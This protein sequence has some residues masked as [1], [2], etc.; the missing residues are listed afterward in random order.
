M[1]NWKLED[2]GDQSGRVAIVT[3]ANTGLGFEVARA[4]A[5]KGASV[6]LACRHPDKAD[7][8]VRSIRSELP[9][10]RVC[11]AQL[12]LADL[13]SVSRFADDFLQANQR[14][15]L[16][17]N[18]AGV[19]ATPLSRTSDNFELQ[20]GT[21]HL[22]HFA[23]AAGLFPLIS[24]AAGSRIVCVSS[25]A[26]KIGSVDL[27]DL[28][29]DKRHYG[30]WKAYAQSK[31]A[32]LYFGIELN[33]R[34][35]AAHSKTSTTMVHPGYTATDLQRHH[36]LMK[37]FVNPLFMK[38]AEGALSVLRAACDSAAAGGSY[39]GPGGLF[40]MKG[41]PVKVEVPHQAENPTVATQLW[42]LSEKLTGFRFDVRSDR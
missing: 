39:W 42:D 28:N 40:E 23:L 19:M 10:A 24:R 22:G 33:R 37:T 35:T 12:D 3:G 4:L 15:D 18:N 29:F 17:V 21:N 5:M 11:R 38:P 36:W 34:L 30:S 2:I 16:L 7:A 13:K 14:L 31:L 27:E 6:F 26:A 32:I 41:A 20:I 9:S 8:A 25:S 1:N